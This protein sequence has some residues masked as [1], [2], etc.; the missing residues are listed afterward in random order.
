MTEEW[1]LKTLVEYG[2]TQQEAEVYTYLVSNQPKETREI[3]QAL[4]IN[5]GRA[6]RILKELQ[7]AKV[8]KITKSFP[9][10]FYVVP[11]ERVLDLLIKERIA[12]ADTLEKKKERILVQRSKAKNHRESL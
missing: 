11:F 4:E 6:Y 2:F 8:V 5:A 3:A 10:Q 9:G 7:E 12:A 1:I